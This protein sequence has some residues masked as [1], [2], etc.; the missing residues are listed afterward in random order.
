M[1]CIV[2]LNETRLIK[3]T[4]PWPSNTI[5]VI[6]GFIL[7]RGFAGF[8]QFGKKCRIELTLPCQMGRKKNR[9]KDKYKVFKN[10]T[11]KNTDWTAAL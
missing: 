1:M 11:D 2:K 10:I 6:T 9:S 7:E 5:V 4:Y 3:N 8:P